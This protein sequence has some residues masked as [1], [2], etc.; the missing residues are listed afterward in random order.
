MLLLYSAVSGKGILGTLRN[1]IQGKKPAGIAPVTDPG[2][3]AV[4]GA[5]TQPVVPQAPVSVSGNVALGRLLAT[6]YGWSVSPEWD[7][8]YNLWERES[9]WDNTADNT[10]SG[11]YGIPQSLPYTK[12]P[13]AAWPESAGGNSSAASQIQWGLSYIKGTYGTPLQAW[14][15]EESAGW[16]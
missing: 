15:H 9:G 16:Y 7:A 10:S 3:G 2:T 13:K 5:I 12:M 4:S 14:A 11:A 1:V 6:P 8:L